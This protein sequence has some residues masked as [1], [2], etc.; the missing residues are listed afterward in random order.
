MDL[1]ICLKQVPDL[2]AGVPD[3]EV[4]VAFPADVEQVISTLDGYAMEAA[5][6]IQDGCSS[7]S[8]TLL[9]LDGEEALRS[10]YSVVGEEVVLIRDPAFECSDPV[11]KGL[12]LAAAAE[13]L[14]RRR[15][16]PFDLI[17]CGQQSADMG[18]GLTGPSLAEA[19]GRP[20]VSGVLTAIPTDNGFRMERETG[21][22]IQTV[23]APRGCVAL[24][25]RSDHP[26]R[27]PTILRNMMAVEMEV[28]V[29]HNE[30][31]P[32]VDLAAVGGVSTRIHTIKQFAPTAKADAVRISASS[33]EAAALELLHGLEHA[34][35][36]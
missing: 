4:G 22:G 18:S 9:S 36:L 13:E 30:D 23:E 33:G 14:E 28:P 6:R 31:L 27:Y 15:G 20:A 25:T 11:G 7:C 3:P 21:R 16:R 19:L 12:I 5:A 1:L 17:L 24:V 34:R 2:A 8:I 26:L 32:A 10:G 35:V 29:L